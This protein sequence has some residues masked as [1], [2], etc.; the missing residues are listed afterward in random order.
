MPPRPGQAG[1]HGL[2][3]VPLGRVAGPL[4]DP[5]CYPPAD[6]GEES[7]I[8]A[9]RDPDGNLVELTQLGPGWLGHLK[10]QRADGNDLVSAW[11]ARLAR[12]AETPP[13]S[14]RT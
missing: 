4:R 10:A 11:G 3:P 13:K 8:T 14:I 6:S 5:L 1:I 7:R 12:L 9:V 2:R